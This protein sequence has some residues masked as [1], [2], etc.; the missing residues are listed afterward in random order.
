[1]CSILDLPCV[2]SAQLEAM[3]GLIFGGIFTRTGSLWILMIAHTAFDLTA[4]GLIYWELEAAVARY[5]FK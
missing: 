3:V 4:L 1:M 5:I 2:E